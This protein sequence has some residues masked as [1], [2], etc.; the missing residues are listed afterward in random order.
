MELELEDSAGNTCFLGVLD[1]FK[2]LDR[3]MH[4][5]FQSE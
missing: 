1:G 2:G 5:V 3:A 4:T